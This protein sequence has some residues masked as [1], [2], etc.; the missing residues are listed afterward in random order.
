MNDWTGGST[1]AWRKLRTQILRRDGHRCRLQLPG[2]TT[3][4]DCVHHLDGKTRGDNPDRLIASCT[5]C[6]LQVGEPTHHDPAPQPR[7]EW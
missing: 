3:I 2:C 7:T 5:R 6:N 1:R 4:A